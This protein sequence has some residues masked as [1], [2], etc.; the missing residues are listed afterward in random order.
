MLL[1]SSQLSLYILKTKQDLFIFK[2][3]AK[4]KTTEELVTIRIMSELQSELQWNWLYTDKTR[5]AKKTANLSIS[6]NHMIVE[7]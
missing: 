7:K 1:Y 2:K 5:E 4:Q 6:I 3:K